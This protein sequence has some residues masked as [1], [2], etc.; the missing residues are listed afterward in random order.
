MDPLVGDQ[1]GA[2]GIE[3][4]FKFE[5]DNRTLTAMGNTKFT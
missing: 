2:S 5:M 3:N 4:C 1:T